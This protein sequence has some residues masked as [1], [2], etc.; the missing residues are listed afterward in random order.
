MTIEM[1]IIGLSVCSAFTILC[2][3]AVKKMLKEAKKK[4]HANLLAA[5]CS[6]AVALIASV[7]YIVIT[8]TT[9]NPAVITEI[10]LL[11]IMSW[12]C[13]MVGHD[14][15]RQTIDQFIVPTKETKKK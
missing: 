14:K 15:V 7:A 3:E 5:V 8:D 2:T 11:T 12:L 13:A 6:V 9:V 10:I 1:F 4:Y